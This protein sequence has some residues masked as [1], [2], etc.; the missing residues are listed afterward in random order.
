MSIPDGF[1]GFFYSGLRAK[2]SPL[3]RNEH[4]PRW[5][6]TRRLREDKDYH[7][8]SCEIKKRKKAE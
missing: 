8:L 6:Q 2:I 7:P 3:N 5:N 4:S 1:E